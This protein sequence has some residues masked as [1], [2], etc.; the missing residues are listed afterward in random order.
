M[1]GII[2]LAGPDFIRPDGQLKPCMMVDGVP[3]LR[4]ALESRAWWCNPLTPDRLVFV[5]QN[6]PESKAFAEQTLASWY[7]AAR[8]VFL[9][10]YTQGAALSALAGLALAG[11]QEAPVCIDLVDILYTMN[12]NPAQRFAENAHLG[13]LVPTFTSSETRF[14]Y[15]RV[16]ENTRT[17]ESVAEKRVIA[18]HA[19]AGTY[20][21]RSPAVLLRALA[22]ALEH[23]ADVMHNNLFYVAPLMN[24][25]VAQGLQAEIMPVLHE[26]VL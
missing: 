24:G 14:S 22:H 13:G 11:A 6:T 4:A 15:C 26:R 20:F 23:R 16:T 3:L 9:S 8:C 5:L 12:E 10:D 7:P 17:I 25:V 2:P 21:F 18:S 19:S 1:I